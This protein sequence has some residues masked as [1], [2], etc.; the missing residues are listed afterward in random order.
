MWAFGR[1][2]KNDSVDPTTTAGVSLLGDSPALIMSEGSSRQRTIQN[3]N[4][5][6]CHD[7]KGRRAGHQKRRRQHKRRGPPRLIGII[8]VMLLLIVAFA[9]IHI[10]VPTRTRKKD[11]SSSR[12]LR[13][14]LI[15]PEE[16]FAPFV[17][18]PPPSS[19]SSLPTK[20]NSIKE[21]K[22]RTMSME[23]YELSVLRGASELNWFPQSIGKDTD[24]TSDDWET[25]EHPAAEVLR[26]FRT[27]NGNGNNDMKRQS[28]LSHKSKKTV[29]VK[30]LAIVLARR[31]NDK[32]PM[33]EVKEEE[34]D[35][36]GSSSDDGDGLMRVPKFW[37]PLPF[38]NIADERQRRQNGGGAAT[39][40]NSASFNDTATDNSSGVR[41]YLGNYGSRLM[42][43]KEAESIGSRIPNKNGVTIEDGHGGGS[44]DDNLL[45][46]IFVAI[47][48][49][50]DW[51]CSRTV[52]SIFGRAAH[53]ER[54]RV[55]VV[56]QVRIDVDAPCSIPPLG[57]CDEFPNQM[58]CRHRHQIDYLTV[59]AGLSVGPV[60]ARHLGHRL[61]RGE[62]F[63]IQS[64]AHVDYV[65][66]WDVDII[67]QWRTAKNEMAILSA[68]LSGIEDHMNITTGVRTSSSRPIMCM[69]D[70]EGGD[71]G[72]HLRHGQQPEGVPY[73]KIHILCFFVCVWCVCVCLATLY[74]SHY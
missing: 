10:I 34:T 8:G 4:V 51:Q 33:E 54:I 53:P 44:G 64:D 50:R 30:E 69:S 18:P 41:R 60:F 48:S 49:Y 40:S 74:S 31:K 72:R 28:L 5:V 29:T 57:P 45:D 17:P 52:E 1:C 62:Y 19:S 59:D 67:D 21:E 73:S 36:S 35:I 14:N 42:T 71:G 15:N 11:G 23:E 9:I 63:A 70:F 46:T 55:G 39:S 58:T 2:V 12:A 6:E 24:G 68:Y 13:R 32:R 65:L 56:D 37:D 61:Y 3:N 26:V 20:P 22:L 38:R 16:V 66:G 47:S 27:G 7:S 43:P 25:I